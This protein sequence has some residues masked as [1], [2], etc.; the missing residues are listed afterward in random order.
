MATNA[1]RGRPDGPGGCCR[2]SSEITFTSNELCLRVCARGFETSGCVCA[3]RRV[4]VCVLSV[5]SHSDIHVQEDASLTTHIPL[6]AF[7]SA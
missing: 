3:R 4:Y 7:K 2:L 6:D 1:T 5:G